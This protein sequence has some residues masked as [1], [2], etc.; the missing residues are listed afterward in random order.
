MAPG[1]EAELI[2]IPVIVGEPEPEPPEL[3]LVTDKDAWP[4]TA[5]T[6][7][8]IV[9]LPCAT[10]VTR[11]EVDTVATDVALDV[12]VAELDRSLVVPSLYVP[13]AVS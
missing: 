7:A 9:E 2:E 4:E 1:S 10:P 13:V 6:V 5:P 11:P 3:L 8:V 12:Q